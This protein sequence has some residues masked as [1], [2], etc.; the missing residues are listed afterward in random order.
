MRTSLRGMRGWSLLELVFV[1]GIAGTLA[2][3]AL[4][5]YERATQRASLSGLLVGVD[6]VATAVQIE[7]AAGAQD[8]HRGAAVGQA[9]PRLRQVPDAAF[10]EPGGVR[11]LLIRAPAGFFASAPGEERYGLV[12]TADGDEG[13]TRLAVLR[14]ALPFA[15]TDKLWLAPNALAFPLVPG[16]GFCAEGGA[17]C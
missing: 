17:P 2:A 11:L 12:A 8:L 7:E 16:T 15:D 5:F 4:P 9:P 3:G 6:Q 10:A 1:L 14:H 13:A